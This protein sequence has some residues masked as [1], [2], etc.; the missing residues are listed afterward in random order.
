M[1]RNAT[2]AGV[3]G[4]ILLLL[5]AAIAFAA[6]V[7]RDNLRVTVSSQIEPFRLPRKTPAPIA[8]FLAGHVASIDGSVPPQLDKLQIKINRHGLLQAK[9]LPICP[10]GEIQPASTERALKN[11]GD[12]LIGSGQFWASIIF[13]GQAPYPTHGRL[14]IFNGSENGKPV[15]LAH[16]FS[17][18]PFAD[19][20]VIT[21]TR[22]HI[23]QGPYGTELTA[24]LPQA[25]GSWDFVNRI[26]LTLRR[27]YHY[28]GQR[29]SYFNAACPAAKGFRRITFPIALATFSFAGGKSVS[30]PVSKSC[31]VKGP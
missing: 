26:K 25:L 3:L 11:C 4:L 14:L 28:R 31:G 12:A 18:N 10:V 20:F 15:L 22:R 29:L 13:P 9:G 27:D 24:S 7:Q 2:R 5:T 30:T 19:S 8:V 21:F 17:S 1:R 23:S 16:I 6:V